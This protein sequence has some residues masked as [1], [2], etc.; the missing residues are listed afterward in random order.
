[1][2]SKSSKTL[3]SWAF[4]GPTAHTISKKNGVEILRELSHFYY[5]TIITSIKVGAKNVIF[6]I[7]IH[8]L[9]FVEL[10]WQI[11]FFRGYKKLQDCHGIFALFKHHFGIFWT[12]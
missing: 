12:P 4:F 2:R 3:S 9:I 7:K 6:G 5:F 8:G 10:S 11:I 1:M